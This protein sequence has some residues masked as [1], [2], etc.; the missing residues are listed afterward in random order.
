MWFFHS[1]LGYHR[2]LSDFTLMPKL[3]PLVVFAAFVYILK[4]WKSPGELSLVHTHWSPELAR[5]F[6]KRHNATAASE[7]MK[8]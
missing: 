1:A 8:G 4:D 7:Q 5:H 2:S 6:P 3:P